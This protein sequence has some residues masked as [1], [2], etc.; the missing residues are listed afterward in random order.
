MGPPKYAKD[1]RS[2]QVVFAWDVFRGSYFYLTPPKAL[3]AVP[4]PQNDDLENVSPFKNGNLWYLPG[5][6]ITSI[7]EGQPPKTRPFPFKTRV[8]WVP[9]MLD[10][11]SVFHFVCV[12][13]ESG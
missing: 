6:Q 9:G 8:I 11:W 7:F 13:G 1:T 10:F 4:G 3:T 12:L 5:T 2:P